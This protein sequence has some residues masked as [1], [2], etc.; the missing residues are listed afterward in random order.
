MLLTVVLV[1][2]ILLPLSLYGTQV[3]NVFY[4][5][6]NRKYLKKSATVRQKLLGEL[7]MD[8]DELDADPK[9][10]VKE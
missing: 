7:P 5:R 4:Q 6:I 3:I 10:I 1:I 9:K 8:E 2:L